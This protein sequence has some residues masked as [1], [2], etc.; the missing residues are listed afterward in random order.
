[1][2]NS[3]LFLIGETYFNIT[4]QTIEYTRIRC[5]SGSFIR[6]LQINSTQ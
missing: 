6:H 1:M 4:K 2:N 5:F 3:F